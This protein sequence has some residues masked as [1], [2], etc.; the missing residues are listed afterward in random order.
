MKR[1]FQRTI[2]LQMGEEEE[3]EEE[4]DVGDEVEDIGVIRKGAILNS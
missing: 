2:V 1:R 4:D 3:E